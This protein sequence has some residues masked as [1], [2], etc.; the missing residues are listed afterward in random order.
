MNRSLPPYLA[1]LFFLVVYF[2]FYHSENFGY[3]GWLLMG[4]F[5]LLAIAFRRSP[6]L[7]G[8]SFTLVIFAAVSLAMYYP[9]YFQ[10]AG[11]I[12]LSVLILPLLQ[13]IMFGMGTELSL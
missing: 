7:K 11:G 4:F 5:I 6:V 12:R 10:K 9:A 3:A 1:A 8:F 2:Y 13:I